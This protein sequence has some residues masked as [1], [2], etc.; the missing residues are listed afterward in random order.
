VDAAT[1]YS[2]RDEI[3]KTVHVVINKVMEASSQDD[4]PLSPEEYAISVTNMDRI[5]RPDGHCCHG[6]RVHPADLWT[7][8]I[9]W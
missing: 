1:G 9:R 2:K 8:R 3:L 7:D 4:K 6:V 5:G